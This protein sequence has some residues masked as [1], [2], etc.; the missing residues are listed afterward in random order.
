MFVE[1]IFYSIL[2]LITL[3]ILHLFY[4]YIKNNYTTKRVKC[5]GKYQNERYLDILHQLKETKSSTLSSLLN[6]DENKK[7]DD[8]FISKKDKHQIQDSL[9]QFVKSNITT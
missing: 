5:I 4:N 8:H 2:C 9:Y 6:K 1:F 3:R 7:E